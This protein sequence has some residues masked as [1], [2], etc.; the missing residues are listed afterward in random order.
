MYN[1]NIQMKY[2]LQDTVLINLDSL[3]TEFSNSSYY[4]KIFRRMKGVSPREFRS[5]LLKF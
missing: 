4:A 2:Y 5:R 3:L 1:L